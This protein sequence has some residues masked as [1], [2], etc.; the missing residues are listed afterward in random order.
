MKQ[1]VKTTTIIQYTKY[2]E[3]HPGHFQDPRKAIQGCL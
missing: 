1:N 3:R 2:S